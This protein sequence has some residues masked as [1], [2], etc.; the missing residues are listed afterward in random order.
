MEDSLKNIYQNHSEKIFEDFKNKANTKIYDGI[1][2]LKISLNKLIEEE[3]Q[4]IISKL[5]DISNNYFNEKIKDEKLIERLSQKKIMLDIGGVYHSTTL[6]TLIKYKESKLAKLFSGDYELEFDSEGRFFIDRN[7]EYFK[8]ILDSLRNDEVLLP[9]SSELKELVLKEFEFFGLKE[10]VNKYI[11]QIPDFCLDSKCMNKESLSLS[12]QNMTV[13]NILQGSG[14]VLGNVEM[15]DGI[16]TWDVEIN[17]LKNDHWVGIGV[18]DK[19]EITEDYT[20]DCD[21]SYMISSYLQHYSTSGN[22]PHLKQGWI[23]NCYLNF[24]EDLFTIKGPNNLDVKNAN[25]FKGE[26][27]FVILNLAT[28]GNQLTVKNFKKIK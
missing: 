28:A 10:F 5:N 18:C 24:E 17:N 15:K 13:S 6:N 4:N 8:Y 20:Y 23:V 1:E 14:S 12:N 22:L 11:P 2:H 26:T 16:F 3:K 21:F 27:L 19:S 9:Q 25:S 7:G